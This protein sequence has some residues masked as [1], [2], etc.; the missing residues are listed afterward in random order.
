MHAAG[1]WGRLVLANC[2]EWR[3]SMNNE[4]KDKNAVE[5]P[6]PVLTYRGPD[7]SRNRPKLHPYVMPMVGI[8]LM[9]EAAWFLQLGIIAYG[10]VVW[11]R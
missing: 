11:R 1:R 2:R 10:L 8:G 6:D 4:N 7:Q 5:D 3:Q 9:P